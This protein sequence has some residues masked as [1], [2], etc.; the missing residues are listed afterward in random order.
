MSTT[1]GTTTSTTWRS[2]NETRSTPSIFA[3]GIGA[4]IVAA[5]A[6]AVWSMT[7]AAAEGLGFWLPVQLIAATFLGVNAIVGGV[8]TIVFGFILHFIT[9]SAWGV[10]FAALLSRTTPLP[11]AALIGILYG[12]G[13]WAVM[14]FLVLPWLD[15]T[16]S[17]RVSVLWWSF[18]VGHLIYGF[19][20]GL[21]VPMFRRAARTGAPLRVAA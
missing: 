13:V 15:P 9:A 1:T 18:L 21:L 20:L 12:L 3:I 6:M 19:A 2:S 14:R 5:V 8:G 7:I 16:M 4:G 11:A 17:V 10:V